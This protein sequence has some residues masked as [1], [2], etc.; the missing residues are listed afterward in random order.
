MPENNLT[1]ETL[2][3]QLYDILVGLS[4][5]GTYIPPAKDCFTD[6]TLDNQLYQILLAVGGI[7]G[8]GVGG[9]TSI[10]G[11]TE[12]VQLIS[13]ADPINVATTAGT[14][15]VSI[16]QSGS[17]SGGYLTSTDWN[18]FNSKLGGSVGAVDNSALRADVGTGVVQNSGI[19]IE[20]AI[21][22]FTGITG[23][24]GTDVITAPGSA[25]TDGQPIRFTALN[26]GTGLNTTTNYYVREV[27]GSTFKVETSIGGGAINFTTNITAGTLLTGHSV[28][29]NVTIS[30]N[31]TET[32]SSLVLS[33]KGTGAFI[34]GPK[35]DGTTTGGNARGASSVDLQSLRTGSGQVASGAN[36]ALLGGHRNTVS[37]VN[38]VICGG[39]DNSATNG[40][41]IV[42]GGLNSQATG[43]TSTICGGTGNS[44]S[45]TV[46]TICG[47]LENSASAT[48]SSVNG[49]LSGRSDRYAQQSHASGAF[50][51]NGDAQRARFV[52][53]N[54]TT[55]NS[56]VELFLDGSTTRL[57]IP[58]G[59]IF[60]FTI[61]ITGTKSDGSAVAH[62]LRQ[63]CLKNVA[64][65]TS[66]VY[67]PVTIGVDNAAGTSI[68]LSA[69]D[70]NDA[71]NVSVTGIAA[72]TWR[73]V[74]AVDA[75]EVAYGT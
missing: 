35:P 23:D 52:M 62:Y 19:I 11:S 29:T 18:T 37:G 9:I 8:G 1:D 21:V 41:D 30:E 49:G 42:V 63:Y 66:Q 4:E 75:V 65:T 74:A 50:S 15:L 17:T 64:G 12:A 10:N 14:T 27:S 57:T 28:Q 54:K 48:G 67:A 61:N 34:L 53:R 5:A 38:A 33:P 70:T 43:G 24:A 6:L 22:S 2:D 73:W 47:G 69:N 13:G 40:Y 3:N 26:G 39:R 25:F 16:D 31:T 7:S 46:S 72:E 60:A 56:A 44:A 20:D 59:K 45:G 36:S 71:L 32:N 58:S 51:A 68:S 55:T